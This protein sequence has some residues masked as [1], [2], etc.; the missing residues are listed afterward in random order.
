MAKEVKRHKFQHGAMS[1]I[2]MGEEL[3]GHPSTALNELVKNG[4]DADAILSRVYF[5]Y[6]DD[7]TRSFALIIDY[8]NGM[9]N[10][11][12]F[13]DWLQ[14]SISAKRKPGARSEIYKRHFLGSKGIGRLAAMALGQYTTVIT[15]REDE[16]VYNWI[17]V[18]REAFKE[19]KLL[20]QIEF[21]GDR[22]ERFCDLFSDKAIIEIR[23]VPQNDALVKI[24]ERNKL[25][26]FS[27]GT[28][29]VIEALDE[30]VIKILEEDFPKQ[31]ELFDQSLKNTDFYKSLATLIT[32]L[33]LSSEIQRELREKGIIQK[34]ISLAAKGSTFSVEFGTN[35]LPDQEENE[36]EWQEIESIPILSVFDYR[37]LGRMKSNGSVEGYIIY[38]RLENDTYEEEFIID[39]QDIEDD[40]LSVRTDNEILAGLSKRKSRTEVGEYYFDVRVYDIGESDNLD[41][42]ARQAGLGSGSK[43]R[44][45]FKYFQGL[46]VSKNGFGVKPYGEEVEDWIGL[47]K[48]RVQDPGHN[49]NTN[50][51]LGYVFFYSPENDNLQ[52]KTNREGFSEN[53]AFIEVKNTLLTIFKNL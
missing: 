25:D 17:T 7:P 6:D 8:G 11:T 20:S 28:L 39:I 34:E 5:Q 42:L 44:E 14:P 18:N 38:S 41:K 36:I 53:T 30:S 24:L 32:P 46:R 35:L 12:L 52:E 29:I 43:F 15:K 40:G 33:N 1:I 13:G 31:T 4:Y 51:I 9:S 26:K 16:P 47:S 23:E 3:I 50:Q 37:V 2:Q 22:I 10:D 48:V 45:A 21:P 27:K 49:V 19:E